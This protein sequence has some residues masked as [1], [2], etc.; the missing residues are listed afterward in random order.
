MTD[1]SPR[2]PHE[3]LHELT[4]AFVLGGLSDADHRAFTA[5]LRG[6]PDCQREVAGLAAIPRL[7]GL[8]DADTAAGDAVDGSIDGYAAAFTTGAP[9]AALGAVA[10]PADGAATELL[11]LLRGRRRRARRRLAAAAAVLAVACVGGGVAWGQAS[12]RPPGPTV[13]LAAAPAD[14][15]STQARVGLVA[16]GWGT[17]VEVA[18]SELPR[19]GTFT[20]VVVDAAGHEQVIGSWSATASGRAN[21]VAPCP[22]SP[23]SISAVHLR[24]NTGQLLAAATS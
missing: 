19:A 4:G 21:L 12:A 8:L 18:A 7:L 16:K 3:R 15:S 2:P 5:H 17:Q 20:L 14:G 23:G 1:G 13:T 24:A 6:C 9:R 10:D 22:W 11:T